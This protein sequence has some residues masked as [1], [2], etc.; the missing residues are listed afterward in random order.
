MSRPETSWNSALNLFF[1]IETIPCQCEGA[2]QNHLDNIA[3]PARYK[4]QESIDKWIKDEGPA[5]AVE[6]WKKTALEGISGQIV[7]IAWA[8]DKFPV[9]G[10]I[11]LDERIVLTDFFDAVSDNIHPGE[12]K[13]QRLTWIGH[14]IIEFDL[15]FLYQRAAINDMLPNF[16]IPT[17]ARH[18]S[19]VFDTM[20][21]WAGWKGYVKQDALYAALGG[22]PFEND[23]MDGS[24]VWDY[25][26]AGRYGEVLAYNKRDVS[27]IRYI[28]E[29]LAWT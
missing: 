20:K 10:S 12:G 8:F 7:S 9:M 1:D 27:K 18:G 15:R 26:Q 16:Q 24:Q 2:L 3:A 11:N 6:A 4:K 25:V 17:D 5:A 21:A 23:D 22:E 28:Y 19:T 13:Y 29:R 14:N